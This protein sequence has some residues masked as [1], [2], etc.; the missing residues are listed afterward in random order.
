MK[1]LR[2]LLMAQMYSHNRDIL[3]VGLKRQAIK[4]ER[5]EESMW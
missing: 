2:I 5:E 3:P 4:K 1:A